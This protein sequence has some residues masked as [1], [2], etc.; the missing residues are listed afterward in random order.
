VDRVTF[1]ALPATAAWLHRDARAGFEVVFFRAAGAGYTIE[2]HTAAVE[3]GN[4]WSIDYEITVDASWLTR[5]AA[6]TSRTASGIR[7][8]VVRTSGNGRWVVNGR[9]A[10]HLNGC[11]D[12]DLEASA[13]TNALPVHR[14]G[15]APGER[16]ETP[17]AYIRA[18][19]GAVERLE[20]SYAR[21]LDDGARQR[22]DYGAPAFGFACELVYDDAGLLLDY[23]GIAIRAG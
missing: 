12:V 20:Q 21:T 3:S 15:L 13:F 1:D 8:T 11:L 7:S 18:L 17:A 19:D 16:A 14:L 4:A 6:M 23:P 22:F 9:A 10:P 2:G 5:T